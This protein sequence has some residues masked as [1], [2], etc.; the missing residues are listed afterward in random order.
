MRK[1]YKKPE[2]LFETMKMNTS[3]AACLYVPVENGGGAYQEP[4]SVGD[5]GFVYI[6]IG[7][8]SICTD[9]P[10]YCYQV[11]APPESDSDLT[12]LINAS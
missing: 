7:E 8:M 12:F 9:P 4:D 10:V 6:N 3:I 11:V 5:P 1:Q 2:I